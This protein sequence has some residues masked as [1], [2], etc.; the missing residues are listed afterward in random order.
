MHMVRSAPIVQSITYSVIHDRTISDRRISDDVWI[1]AA[2]NRQE[3]QAHTF[4]MPM[5][6]RDRFAEVEITV[7]A[8]NWVQWAI[9]SGINPHLIAF[10]S[11]K[12][13]YLYKMDAASAD[14]P[15]TPRGIERASKLIGDHDVS[16]DMA[17]MMLSIST[18][19]AF[20]TEFQAYVKCY[21]KVNWAQLM[22]K[23][24][25]AK[26]FDVGTTF[27]VGAGLAERFA[28]DPTDLKLFEA[29]MN[30]TDNFRKEDFVLSTFKMMTTY[31]IA[32]FGKGIRKLGRMASYT[33]KYGKF[34]ID[35]GS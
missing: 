6:L 5:P 17:H 16:S 15:S 34:M 31:D 18:G 27:A 24:E 26:D 19:E 4:D 10:V 23:P 13:S 8:D 14:K 20:A 9:E 28:K 12:P 3:D 2:G 11:W 21:R 29:I 35:V 25:M 1:F 30:V 33:R 22:K 7:N 32:N